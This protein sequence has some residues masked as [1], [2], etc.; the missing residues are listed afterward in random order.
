MTKSTFVNGAE[1]IGEAL[2]ARE[3]KFFANVQSV[4]RGKRSGEKFLVY[5]KIYT[6]SELSAKERYI[7]AHDVLRGAGGKWFFVS[8]FLRVVGKPL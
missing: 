1:I 2:D 5:W 4:V 3:D 8:S 7:K 6:A